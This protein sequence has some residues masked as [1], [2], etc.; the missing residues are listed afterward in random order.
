MTL[1]RPEYCPNTDVSTI[2]LR[3]DGDNSR[4]G[5]DMVLTMPMM[6]IDVSRIR[7][8][9]LR[10]EGIRTK[11]DSSIKTRR[12]VSLAAFILHRARF[13]KSDDL[14]QQ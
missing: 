6:Q 2:A 13:R 8:L 9:V 3:A 5:R 12:A 11:P 7:L 1:L 4:D 10:T 14:K